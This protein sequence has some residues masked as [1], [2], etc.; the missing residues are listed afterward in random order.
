MT[1][2]IQ[3]ISK[4]D[5]NFAEI[6]QKTRNFSERIIENRYLAVEQITDFSEINIPEYDIQS[7]QITVHFRIFTSKRIRKKESD[8]KKNQTFEKRSTGSV[9]NENT[10]QFFEVSQWR[11]THSVLFGKRICCHD[12]I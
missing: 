4:S 10:Q 2:G 9:S 11:Q 8:F 1:N 6:K 12:F 7:S 5:S 3:I